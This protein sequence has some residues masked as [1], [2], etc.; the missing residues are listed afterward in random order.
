M[1][2]KLKVVHLISGLGQGGAENVLMRLV[3]NAPQQQHVVISMTDA[4]SYGKILEEHG[5]P[6]H[7]L[8]LPNGKFNLESLQR[9]MRALKQQAPDVLQTWMYHADFIGGMAAR[10]VGIKNIVWGIRNSGA[11]L[12]KSSRSSYFLARYFGW[13]SYFIPKKIIC[14]AHQAKRRHALWHYQKNKM[15]VIPNGYD[16]SR[17]HSDEQARQDGRYQLG[18]QKDEPVLGFVA[19]WNPLKDHANLIKALAL[20]AQQKYDFKCLL[21]GKD[22]STDNAELIRLLSEHNVLGQ[23][24]LLGSRS[25]VPE[26]M[27]VMDIHVLSS[28]AEGFPNVVAEAMA[29]GTPCVVTDVGDAAEIVADT[30]WVVPP[31]DPKAMAKAIQEAL[32]SLQTPERQARSTAA[33]EHILQ[34]FSLQ[35]MVSR[36]E[37]VWKEVYEH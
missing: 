10:L 12:E 2:K 7:C 34:N 14:C 30:G 13:T 16:M 19:R 33:R 1:Q 15:Q 29:C 8:G 4:G 35:A 32:D 17:W 26:L 24:I 3:L 18:I 28:M 9:L 27:N 20:C 21:I 11:N 37:A 31:S 36:Y 6:V 25:D 23:V 22:M 5:V